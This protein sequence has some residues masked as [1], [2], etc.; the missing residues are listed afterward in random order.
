MGLTIKAHKSE[1]LIRKNEGGNGRDLEMLD[2]GTCRPSHLEKYP[3]SMLILFY[4]TIQL[5]SYIPKS[6][7][8]IL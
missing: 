4:S 7:A 6:L 8:P 2:A 3:C 1:D 5:Y